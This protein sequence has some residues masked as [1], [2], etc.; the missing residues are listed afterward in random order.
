MVPRVCFIII[1]EGRVMIEMKQLSI[2]RL[3]H[4]SLLWSVCEIFCSKTE[5]LKSGAASSELFPERAGQWPGK[6]CLC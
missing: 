1:L 6:E 3:L 2:K 5:R 4:F